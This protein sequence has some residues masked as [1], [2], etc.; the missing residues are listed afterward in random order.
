[1]VE[2][3]DSEEIWKLFHAWEK[4]FLAECKENPPEPYVGIDGEDNPAL[5]HDQ[6]MFIQEY[7][8]CMIMDASIQEMLERVKRF[9]SLQTFKNEGKYLELIFTGGCPIEVHLFADSLENVDIATVYYITEFPHLQ[10]Y[11]EQDQE[12]D[13]KSGQEFVD[14][15]YDDLSFDFCDVSVTYDIP[16][17]HL[18]QI[19]CQVED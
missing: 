8:A 3:I 10:V 1:M 2:Q 4:A 15:V 19:D 7:V 14:R 9:L 16:N 5:T 17:P 6:V 11:R 12:W 18:L 13:D